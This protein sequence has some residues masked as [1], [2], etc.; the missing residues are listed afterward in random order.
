MDAKGKSKVG[1]SAK[2][3]RPW[4]QT[5]LRAKAQEMLHDGVLAPS[6]VMG[7]L[8]A[9]SAAPVVDLELLLAQPRPMSVEANRII[10]DALRRSRL[11]HADVGAIL[12]EL[13]LLA[14]QPKKSQAPARMAPE[15]VR[16]QMAARSGVQNGGAATS[17]AKR[18]ASQVSTQKSPAREAPIIVRRALKPSGPPDQEHGAS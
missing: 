6:V 1:G 7:N 17:G 18:A 15:P 13:V 9:A 12:D 10:A 2:P 14:W 16:R 4:G 5:L 11:P 8:L 3:S